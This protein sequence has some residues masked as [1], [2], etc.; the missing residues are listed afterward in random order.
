MAI[1]FQQEDVRQR[2]LSHY[3][4]H[5]IVICLRIGGTI[6]NGKGKELAGALRPLA[7]HK[8]AHHKPKRKP[9]P[10]DTVIVAL[11]IELPI[12]QD[13]DEFFP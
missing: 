8:L 9:I 13:V 10:L 5:T 4:T 11:H 2:I 7:N 3:Q 1:W 6:P 12:A